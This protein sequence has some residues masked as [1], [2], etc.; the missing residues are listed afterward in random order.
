LLRSFKLNGVNVGFDTERGFPVT[1]I[2]KLLKELNNSSET[3]VFIKVLK[4]KIVSRPCEFRCCL[5]TSNS[6]I[7][8]KN[9][10]ANLFTVKRGYY[11]K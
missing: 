2:E 11:V 6:I 8:L 5:F 4:P 3:P 7:C 1:S 10:K 9:M